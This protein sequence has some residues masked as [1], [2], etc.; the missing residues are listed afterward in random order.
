MLKM[1]DN[2]ASN[3]QLGAENEEEASQPA[4][5]GAVGQV[6][7][8][9]VRFGFAVLVLRLAINFVELP[10]YMPDVLKVAALF[11]VIREGVHGLGGL[12]GQWQWL[13]LF[14][15]ADIISFIALCWLLV[16]FKVATQG[17]TALKIAIATEVASYFVMLLIGVAIVFGFHLLF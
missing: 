15:A 1:A 13:R 8:G 6:V 3:G 12:G 2:Y 16:Q 11:V 14:Y 10:C 9:L 4:W 7:L 5:A 17:I